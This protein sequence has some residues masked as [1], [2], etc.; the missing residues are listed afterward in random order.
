MPITDAYL[1]GGN[2]PDQIAGVVEDRSPEAVDG[3]IFVIDK[4]LRC[5]L[6]EEKV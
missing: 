2:Q 4:Y 5:V 6:A 3:L 1:A